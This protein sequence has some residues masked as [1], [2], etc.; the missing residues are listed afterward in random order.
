MDDSSSTCSTDSAPSVV[1]NG[2]HKGNS[3]LKCQ[4]QTSS[5]IGTNRRGKE[6]CER[7]VRASGKDNHSSEPLTDV[8]HQQ[9][10]SGITSK[11]VGPES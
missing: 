8:G 6:K 3:F 9:D 2:P 4:T 5:N 1:I 11:A 10:A 7:A